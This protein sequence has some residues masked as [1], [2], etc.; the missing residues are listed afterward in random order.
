MRLNLN[1]SCKK[2]KKMSKLR[3]NLIET[4]EDAEIAKFSIVQILRFKFS[5]ELEHKQLK[6]KSLFLF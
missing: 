2:L 1:P 6:T 4:F 5:I 3:S